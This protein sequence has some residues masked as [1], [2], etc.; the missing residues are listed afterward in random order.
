[1]ARYCPNGYRLWCPVERKIIAGRDVKFDEG[2]VI[3]IKRNLDFLFDD[4]DNKERVESDVEKEDI[5][6]L[7]CNGDNGGNNGD[8][9]P[10]LRWSE[11]IKKPPKYL[12]DYATCAYN[13]ESYVNNLPEGYEELIDRSDDKTEYSSSVFYR[14]GICCISK[15]CHPGVMDERFIS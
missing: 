9:V 12:E 3:K 4:G 2:S 7:D 15:C 8:N 10:E 5:S 14:S 11:R 1:M 13:T 6:E